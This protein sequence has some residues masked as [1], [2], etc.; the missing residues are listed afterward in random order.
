MCLATIA[1][2]FDVAFKIYYSFEKPLL[3]VATNKLL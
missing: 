3:F 2:S 1:S